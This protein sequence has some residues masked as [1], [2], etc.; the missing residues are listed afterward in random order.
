MAGELRL[1]GKPHQLFQLPLIKITLDLSKE[2]NV[3][4]VVGFFLKDFA[5]RSDGW[6]VGLVD[7]VQDQLED[8]RP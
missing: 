7:V 8:L 4:V 1:F 6:K 3:E 5:G 2:S